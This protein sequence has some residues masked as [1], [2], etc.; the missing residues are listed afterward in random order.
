MCESERK[1]VAQNVNKH[2]EAKGVMKTQKTHS[3]IK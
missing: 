2:K 3:L 1:K